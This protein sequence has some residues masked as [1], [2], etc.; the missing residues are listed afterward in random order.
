MKKLRG[1]MAIL[2]ATALIFGTV[3]CS[4]GDDNNNNNP[5]PTD[6]SD[7]I[8]GGGSGESDPISG[9]GGSEGGEIIAAGTP[10][11]IKEKAGSVTGRYL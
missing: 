11:D 10:E 1:I 9:G 8:S 6:Q 7:P 5:K 3:A 2:A 4:G